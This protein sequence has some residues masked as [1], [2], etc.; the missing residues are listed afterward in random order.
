VFGGFGH[1]AQPQQQVPAAGG[2]G[3]LGHAQAGGFG[4][5]ASPAPGAFG[6]PAAGQQQQQPEA[7]GFQLQ[8]G[9]E[10]AFV[11]GAPPAQ[12]PAGRRRVAVRRR[13]RGA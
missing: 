2:F 13:G 3:G 1:A 6:A 7:Q 8:G 11:V 12:Q 9:G 5:A 4:Q 10:P